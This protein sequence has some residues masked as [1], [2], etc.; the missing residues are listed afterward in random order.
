MI[1]EDKW[2]PQRMPH[3]LREAPEGGSVGLNHTRTC[4]WLQGQKLRKKGCDS[5]YSIKYC[6]YVHMYTENTAASAKAIFFD[7]CFKF[8]AGVDVCEMLSLALL[9]YM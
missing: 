5:Y 9:V 8:T 2:K 6:V 1:K 4:Q 7:C 3:I